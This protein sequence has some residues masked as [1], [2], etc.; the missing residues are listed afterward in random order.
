MTNASV[1]GLTLTG[2]GTTSVVTPPFFRG[3]RA[4]DV[5]AFSG[6]TETLA[7]D[8]AGRLHFTVDLGPPHMNQEYTVNADLAGENTPGY[9]TNRTATFAPHAVIILGRARIRPSAVLACIRTLGPAVGGARISVL[10]R[11]N[12]LV[13]RRRRIA[14]TNHT[15]CLRLTVRKP[16]H[17]GRYTINVTGTDVLGHRVSASRRARLRLL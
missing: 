14:I 16:L 17:P 9:F 5:A 8:A 11:Q 12:R 15:R 1:K 6:G 7:P 2:S 10:N 3:L 13:A 4:V